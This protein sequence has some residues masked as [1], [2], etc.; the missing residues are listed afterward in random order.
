MNKYIEKIDKIEEKLANS[1]IS[2]AERAELNDLIS[3]ART[4]INNVNEHNEFLKTKFEEISFSI[5]EDDL[6]YYKGVLVNNLKVYLGEFDVERRKRDIAKLKEM[7]FIPITTF[8][9]LI[10]A[11]GALTCI[12]AILYSI[13]A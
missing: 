7:A 9:L 13:F 1:N 6:R 8:G 5:P 3:N 11:L 2:D 4:S 10:T 12:F